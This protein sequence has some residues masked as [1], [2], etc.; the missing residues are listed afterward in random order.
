M[1]IE[2]YAKAHLKLLKNFLQKFQII[3]K[4]RINF[5]LNKGIEYWHWRI[6]HLKEEN[7]IIILIIGNEKK[8]NKD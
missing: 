3:M 6:E 5:I 1:N 2:C 7:K 8:R 4:R